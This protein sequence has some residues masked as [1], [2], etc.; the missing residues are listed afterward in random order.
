MGYFERAAESAFKETEDG[1]CVYYPNGIIGKGRI[2]TSP[3]LKERIYI[4]HKNTMKYG[5]PIALMAGLFLKIS[6]VLILA[7]IAAPIF[8]WYQHRLI[9]GL[10]IH[11]SKN[12][13]QEIYSKVR[14]PAWY[15]KLLLIL[16]VMGLLF[17]LFVFAFLQKSYLVSFALS[18]LSVVGIV[19]SLYLKKLESKKI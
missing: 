4:F 18:L 7:L 11:N 8:Y 9:G 16:G 12:T 6:F 17:S 13:A 10:K 14:F 3:E 19:L 15:R 2:V 5:I 1:L